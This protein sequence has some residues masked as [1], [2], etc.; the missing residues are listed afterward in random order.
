MRSIFKSIFITI[1]SVILLI[2]CSEEKE[3]D[4]SIIG[5]WGMVSGTISNADGTT[6]R[7][8]KLSSGGYYQ[9]LEFQTE[10]TLI[11]ITM[12][13]Y[14]KSYG[15]YT[16]NN[17]TNE[18]SYKFDGNKYY[19]PATVQIINTDEMVITTD[20]GT[21]IGKSTQYFVKTD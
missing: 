17:V 8:N 21:N 11:R 16:F 15:V 5:E 6:I 1:T 10:G 2:S 4:F 18:L 9:I 19:F 12:P 13:D 14:I 3:K 20:Y 7:Y